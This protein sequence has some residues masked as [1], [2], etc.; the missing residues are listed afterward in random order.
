M[1]PISAI[2]VAAAVVAFVDFGLK[3]ANAAEK[4]HHSAT[5]SVEENESVK[6]MKN[7]LIGIVHE[8]QQKQGA[9]QNNGPWIKLVTECEE[10][11]RE[12]S[13]LLDS[14]KLKDRN[15]RTEALCV[16]LKTV[17]KKDE[18]ERLRTKLEG[19]QTQVLLQITRIIM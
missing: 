5:G 1:H 11:S 18:V 12:L 7:R 2:G 14:L 15:S 4:A 19:H 17:W 3:V 10:T 16:G 9:A 13:Q 6:Q 8:L